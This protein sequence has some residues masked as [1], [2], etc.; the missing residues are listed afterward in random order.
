MSDTTLS[1][2]F[3]P[4]FKLAQNNATLLTRVSWSPEVLSQMANG[5]GSV[6]QRGQDAAVGSAQS[7]A[8]GE[9]MQGLFDN[10]TQ[11]VADIVRSSV[12]M[13]MQAQTTFFERARDVVDSTAN[14]ASGEP[15]GANDE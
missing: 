4:F 8:I 2:P 3:L 10:Y 5:A 7:S 12:G 6:L 1:S 9:V 15:A 11:F 14:A 13:L